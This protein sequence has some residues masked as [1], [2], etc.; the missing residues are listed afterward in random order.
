MVGGLDVEHVVRIA[1]RLIVEFTSDL[2]GF[3]LY[4]RRE[5]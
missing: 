2:Q 1:R 4:G 5:W 3:H